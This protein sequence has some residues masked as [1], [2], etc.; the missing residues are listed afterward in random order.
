MYSY[1]DT[2]YIGAAHGIAGILQALLSIPHMLETNPNFKTEIKASI[3]FILSLQT[4]EGNFAPAM[5]EL[6][7]HQRPPEEELV[8][9]CHGCP[10]VAWLMAKAYLI[11]KEDKYLNSCLR[12]GECIWKRGLLRKGPGI[13]HGIAGNGYVFLLLY[14]LTNDSKHLY[15]AQQFAQFLFTDEFKKAR[16]PDSPYSLYEGLAGTVCYLIDV[17]APENA[18]FPLYFDIFNDFE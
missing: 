10:G 2:E 14:R 1:Y 11:W 6:G 9:W 8:H 18:L 13:C 16:I 7:R 5:D 4:A 3:D 17:F 12:S 15:R